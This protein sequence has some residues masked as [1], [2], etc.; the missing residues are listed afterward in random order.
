VRVKGQRCRHYGL[1]NTCLRNRHCN[2]AQRL[3]LMAITSHCEEQARG[4][5][6]GYDIIT[7]LQRQVSSIHKAPLDTDD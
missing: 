4:I 7:P 3:I 5:R 6:E 1:P 2:F